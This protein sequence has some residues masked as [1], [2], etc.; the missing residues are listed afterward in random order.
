[1]RAMGR[2]TLVLYVWARMFTIPPMDEHGLRILSGHWKVVRTSKEFSDATHGGTSSNQS[3]LNKSCCA[4]VDPHLVPQRTSSEKGQIVV[5]PSRKKTLSVHFSNC[6]VPLGIFPPPKP[7]MPTISSPPPKSTP[8]HSK[9]HPPKT[10][11]PTTDQPPRKRPATQTKKRT[12]TT[13][14]QRSP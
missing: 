11:K 9:T 13:T 5:Q 14:T 1:M 6:V 12:T 3:T 2:V 10:Q 4:L 7:H 8:N